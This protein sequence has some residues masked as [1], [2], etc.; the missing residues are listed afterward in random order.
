[1]TGVIYIHL[2]D[3]LAVVIEEPERLAVRRVDLT[4]PTERD[5]VVSVDWSGISSGTERLL[6]TGQMPPFPGMGYP[7]VP[8]YESVGRIVRPSGDRQE[9]ELVFV[10]GSRG[11]RDIK[12]LFGGAASQLVVD[13]DRVVPLDDAMGEQGTLLALAATA[14]HA[15][16]RAGRMPELIIGHGVLGRLVARW[17][18]SQGG[19][20]IVW[21]KEPVRR[22]GARGYEVSEPGKG[23]HGPIHC[24]IDVSGHDSII[25]ELVPQLAPRGTIVLA[26]FYGART[27]FAFPAAFMREIELR[28]AA[29]WRPEDLPDVM[30]AL[31]EGRLELDDLITHRASVPEASAAYRTA[32]SDPACLKMLLDWRKSP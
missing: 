24:A 18:V 23:L 16:V 29:E 27:S 15:V 7:L 30:D 8:G 10:P 17:V 19:E 26:G 14:R 12:G 5:V 28:I 9:G 32:F 20:P 4:S 22:E 13:R 6:W 21:E 25:D 1:M 11:F 3:A 31:R 2:M